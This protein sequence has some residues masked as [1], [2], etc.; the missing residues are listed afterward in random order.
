MDD[1]AAQ[2]SD[3]DNE[4]PLSKKQRESNA[5]LSDSDDLAELFTADAGTAIDLFVTCVKQMMMMKLIED[6]LRKT[7]D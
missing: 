4:E 1:T 2:F 7:N 3:I 5:A 6:T